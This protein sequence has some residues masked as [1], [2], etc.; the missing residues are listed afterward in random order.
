MNKVVLAVVL[1]VVMSPGA[2]ASGVPAPSAAQGWQKVMDSP[3]NLT[4]TTTNDEEVYS[5]IEHRGLLYIGYYTAGLPNSKRA[6]RLYT[7]DGQ[8]EKLKYTFG[9][10]L[11]FASVQALGEYQGNLYA[12]MSGLTAGD[13][14]IYV[15]K[16]DGA[17]WTRS[18]NTTQ[19]YFCSALVVFNGKL[20][21]GMGYLASRIVAFD[22][23]TWKVVYPGKAGSGLVE[24]MIVYRGKLYAALGGSQTG[25]AAVVYTSDGVTWTVDSEFALTATPYM[26]AT[27]FAEFKGKLYAGTLKGGTTGG[28]ILVLDST[29]GHWSVAWSNPNGNR[30]H[31]LAVYNGRLYAGNA[32][33][34]DAGDVYVSDDGVTFTK[35]LDTPLREVFRLYPYNGSLYLGGGFTNAQAQ[36]W[37]KN[38]S[39]Q[40]RSALRKLW[41]EESIAA[42]GY[43]SA[44]AASADVAS[45]V[46]DR[47][48][49]AIDSL[50]AAFTSLYTTDA[51][52]NL[53]QLL[54]DREALTKTVIQTAKT[55]PAN[56]TLAA[57]FNDNNEAI[58]ALLNSLNDHVSKDQI[59]DLFAKHGQY[60]VAE[61]LAELN[62]DPSGDLNSYDLDRFYM[63][64]LADVIADG[65]G[66]QL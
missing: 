39:L 24:W 45:P 16:D 17:T 62:N 20:Y 13:G 30:V 55:D 42:R 50:G 37:R 34:V 1:A 35:D 28:D 18:Y 32:N 14:D 36:V 15:S 7:W 4:G 21:G 43:V 58:A 41:E 56:P 11:S 48:L 59:K 6:A 38:D 27:A 25:K 63:L 54:R 12:A 51:G 66:N 64:K 19:D 10:S 60:V 65:I 31:A 53:A 9:T 57:Q 47:W 46:E 3:S 22:G 33:M 29:T 52:L 40:L 23:A 61:L 5:M 8:T 44:A 2:Y 26:E 49:V